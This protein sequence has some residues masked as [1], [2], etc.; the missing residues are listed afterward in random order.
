MQNTSLSANPLRLVN[1]FKLRHYRFFR[2]NQTHLPQ[3][4][5]W[6][7]NANTT[8]ETVEHYLKNDEGLP[9]FLKMC[10]K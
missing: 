1:N 8:R 9:A 4:G 5:L 2:R 6:G 10:W 7:N 3:V